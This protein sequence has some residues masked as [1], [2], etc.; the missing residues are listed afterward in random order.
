MTA[1]SRRCTAALVLAA[2]PLLIPSA[3]ADDRADKVAYDRNQSLLENEMRA[4][5]TLMT[6]AIL[7]KFQAVRREW[8]TLLVNGADARNAKDMEVIQ[9]GLDY[10]LYALT[11]DIGP[12][13]LGVAL[14][15]ARRDLRTAGRQ[16]QSARKATFRRL[17]FDEALIR[18][19]KMLKSNF[20]G[21]S[22]AIELLTDLEVVPRD[23]VNP[24]VRLEFHP[25]IDELFVEILNDPKQSDAV[26]T[27]VTNSVANF[28]QR[29]EIRPT[30]QE[31][32]ARALCREAGK[33]HT[34][35]GYQDSLLWALEEFSIAR[36]LADEERPIIMDV[37]ASIL[38]D[39]GR[40]I[41]VR[42][43]A[44]GVMGRAGFDGSTRY[45]ATAWLAAKTT[46]ELFV[47]FASAKPADRANR[48]WRNAASHLLRCF[49]H[50][51]KEERD[52]KDPGFPKGL[53]NR[54]AR[55][56]VV[57]DAFKVVEPLIIEI[58]GGGPGPGAAAALQALGGWVGDSKPSELIYDAKSPP[59]AV[60]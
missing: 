23:P 1:E 50:W 31:P 17:V 28:L 7:A 60:N 14:T 9:A 42:C 36:E 13:A 24:R 11:G 15:A 6:P 38:T 40:N 33:K 25:E 27:R 21:R 35:V 12:K 48:R 37:A 49:R 3:I 43:H 58:L 19:R 53:M 30:D 52:S 39:P 8:N 32:I 2:L 10:R 34:S 51:T 26:K 44:A 47:A 22:M 55:N 56:Q 54:D 41:L 57:A 16:L 46:E 5:Q 45:P 59:L 29:G 18:I 20:I 4:Q